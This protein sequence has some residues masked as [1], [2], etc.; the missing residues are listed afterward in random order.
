MIRIAWGITGSGDY[1]E[2]TLEVMI[3][4]S[5]KHDDVEIIPVLSKNAELVLKWYKFY[6]KLGEHFPKIKI[7]KGP[8]IPFIAGPLQIGA[9][10]FM[11]VCPATGNTTAKIAHG[12]ADSLITNAVAQ[13]M[14]GNIP[15]YIYP[16]D[17]RVGSVTTDLPDGRK[18]TL[19]MRQVDK[20]NVDKLRRMDGITVLSRPREIMGVIQEYL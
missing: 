6:D 11:V 20:D 18:F 14:K 19:T 7:E 16:V 4:I 1:L 15:I 5:E 8:N 10:K 3:E 12:I 9:Y 13:A 2:E 17:Q